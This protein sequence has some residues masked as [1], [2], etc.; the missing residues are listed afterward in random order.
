M[1]GP[2]VCIGP[3]LGTLIDAEGNGNPTA[4]C[5]GDDTTNL[6]DEDGITNLTAVY[7]QGGTVTVTVSAACKLDAWI[8]W[9]NDGDFDLPQEQVF[10]ST[11]LNVVGP[12]GNNLVFAVPAGAYKNDPLVSRWRV[13]IAGGLPPGGPASNG[14]VED[15]RGPIVLCHV[16]NVVGM[17][18]IDA[19]AAIEANGFTVGAI[20]WDSNATVCY[21]KVLSTNPPYC[22]TG[23]CGAVDINVSD[24]LNCF[25]PG[26]A[27]YAQW[28]LQGK[29]KSWC[30]TNQRNGGATGDG[31][32][33]VSDMGKIKS[34]W[35]GNWATDPNAYDCRADFT[36]DGK[37]NISDM[38]KLKS[39]W[40]TNYGA[41][42]DATWKNDCG[43]DPH[44][45]PN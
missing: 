19:N 23:T 9:N 26:D 17:W 31:K 3:I 34:Y 5:N 15:Y 43:C 13:S 25:P 40:G 21:R 45:P 8:D 44:P 24:R 11:Q 6:P 39:N 4:N 37:V 27:K 7:N 36:H 38:G 18:L 22:I 16:P 2:E 10:T 41:A 20:H 1:A 29:P 14:E 12:P 30:C 28:V 33:N 42:C 35:G 32:V